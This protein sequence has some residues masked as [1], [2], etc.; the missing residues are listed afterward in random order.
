M[1]V[2]AQCAACRL[3]TELHD[4]VAPE[5]ALGGGYRL[6]VTCLISVI[7]YTYTHAESMDNAGIGVELTPRRAP[8]HKPAEQGMGGAPLDTLTSWPAAP[9]FSR[10]AVSDPL[11]ARASHA[12]PRR[13]PTLRCP[14]SAQRTKTAPMPQPPTARHPQL[15]DQN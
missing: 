10:F 11:T 2:W 5:S 8:A 14:A 9:T 4:T 1:R 13:D 15:A 7:R 12:H 6:P 3:A